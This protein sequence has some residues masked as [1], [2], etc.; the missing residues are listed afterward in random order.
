[1][2]KDKTGLAAK[3]KNERTPLKSY[4]SG[5]KFLICLDASAAL[6][7]KNSLAAL[8]PCSYVCW[9]PGCIVCGA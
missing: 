9:G 4:A 8:G 3:E 6:E 7:E 5:K 1:M 2:S